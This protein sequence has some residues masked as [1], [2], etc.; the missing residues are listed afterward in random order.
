MKALQL[1]KH[2]G[3]S[4]LNQSWEPLLNNLGHTSRKLVKYDEAIAFHRQALVL[5]P[6]SASTYSSIGYVGSS[7]NS[8]HSL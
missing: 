1:L 3:G 8:I 5:R 2:V 6:L 7:P 4:A